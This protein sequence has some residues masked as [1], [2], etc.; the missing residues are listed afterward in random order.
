[1]SRKPKHPIAVHENEL[2]INAKYC[3]IPGYILLTDSI[4]ITSFQKDKANY[5][6]IQ[7]AKDWFE[8]E[9]EHGT[10]N[11]YNKKELDGYREKLRVYVAILK[12][13][14]DDPNRFEFDLPT[15]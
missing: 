3:G 6:K 4:G 13:H 9:I 2:Y 11:D 1:M 14:D 15:E 5:I 12:Q 7:D 10:K 8:N